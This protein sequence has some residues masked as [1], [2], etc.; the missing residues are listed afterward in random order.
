MAT[1]KFELIPLSNEL[2]TKVQSTTQDH[3]YIAYDRA[4]N[5]L[6]KLAE[7]SGRKELDMLVIGSGDGRWDRKLVKAMADKSIKIVSIDGYEPNATNYENLKNKV[8]KENFLGDGVNI[9]LINEA[10]SGETKFPKGNY[11]LITIAHV[12]YYLED[13]EDRKKLFLNL[14]NLLRPGGTIVIVHGANEFE[15]KK[16]AFLNIYDEGMDI[17]KLPAFASQLWEEFEPIIKPDVKGVNDV[18]YAYLDFGD[19]DK[20]DERFF[21]MVGVILSADI[22]QMPKESHG[23]FRQIVKNNSRK[24]A[25]GTYHMYHPEAILT[26]TKKV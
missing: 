15:G 16:S 23:L 12:L 24:Q 19:V 14:Q 3:Y 11:D 2:Y 17:M 22:R 25:D 6:C 26:Y 7:A 5:T 13:P 8:E 9:N 1:E 21:D 4:T 20:D 18:F 10:V